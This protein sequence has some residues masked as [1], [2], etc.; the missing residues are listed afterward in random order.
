MSH[1]SQ[2]GL[3]P[4][5]RDCPDCNCPPCPPNSNWQL[6][7]WPVTSG[8][9]FLLLGILCTILCT[10]EG[11]RKVL[12]L[13]SSPKR[14]LSAIRAYLGSRRDSASAQSTAQPSIVT[15]VPDIEIDIPSQEARV[16]NRGFSRAGAINTAGPDL[17]PE[18][19]S[20]LQQG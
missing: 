5:V 14:G 2:T 11:R 16:F 13:L 15:P 19:E 6:Y 3:T 1:G 7:G 12:R 9:V 10:D 4:F 18:S 20:S 17:T 8:V